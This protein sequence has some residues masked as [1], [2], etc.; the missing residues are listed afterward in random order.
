MRLHHTKHHQAY[1]DK[2]NAALEKYPD[3]AKKS[4]EELLPDLNTV[5]EDIRLAVRN[6]GGGHYNHT[7][8]WEMLKP[9]TGDQVPQPRER[10]ISLLDKYFVNFD[11]FKQQF[12]AAALGHFGSGWVWLVLKSDGAAAI[13]ATANQDSPISA[14]QKVLLGVDVWEHAYYLKYQNRRAE[15]LEA[16]WHVG[17]WAKV[18]ELLSG[19]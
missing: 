19:Q 18:E 11:G 3:L 13:V 14:G 1:V 15:Y 8:F 4:V 2:L 6:H 16:F 12:T 17:N 7:L 10:T 9:P 5:P